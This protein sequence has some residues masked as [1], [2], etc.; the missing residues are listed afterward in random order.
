MVMVR[1][2]TG[3][4]SRALRHAMRLSVRDFAAKLGAGARSVTKWEA[5]RERA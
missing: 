1:R 3:R 5:Q 4:E 2:W